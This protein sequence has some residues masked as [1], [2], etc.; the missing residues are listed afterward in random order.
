M[1]RFIITFSKRVRYVL[2]GDRMA[3]RLF[4][5]NGI[6]GIFNDELTPE[7][8]TELGLAIGSCYA[9]G[10]VVV[11]CDSRTSSFL[12]SRAVIAGLLSTGCT[13]HDAGPAPTPAI[14]FAVRC[15]RLDGA[16]IVTASHNPPEYNGIKV[17][18]KD[19]VEIARDEEETIEARFFQ[20]AYRR[21][22][23]DALGSHYIFPT[24]IDAYKEAVKKQVDAKAISAKRFKVVVDPANSVGALS[25]PHL[26]RELGCELVSINAHLDGT[27]PGRL[28]EPK[29]ETLGGLAATVKAVGADLGVAHDGDADRCVFVD[30][31]GVVCLGDRT[32]ALM[33]DYLLPRHPDATVVTPISSSRIIEDVTHH[34]GATL[35]WTKVGS[36]TVSKRMQGLNAVL[37]LEDNGGLF[38]APHQP[39]RDGALAASLML[40]ILAKRDRPLSELLQDLPQYSIVKE[41]VE[42][43]NELKPAVLRGVVA[44]TNGLKR[45][46]LDGVKVFYEDGSV[47]IRPSGT[48]AIYRVYAEAN[49]ERRAKEIAAWGLSLVNGCLEAAS[50]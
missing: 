14:Q 44:R 19:G 38:Y 47:L 32:G 41:R 6:R 36:T 11:G 2:R 42:C 43:P 18:A 26:L 48:E 21:G 27:F 45:Q 20:K 8:A 13:V 3:H 4:G 35:V 22:A 15:Y 24:I 31:T 33:L 28:P 7:Y 29:P 49:D 23:W 50:G 40:E 46:T 17:V 5:T 12:L 25:T 10:K 9:D 30:E 39:V 16:V 1:E 37:G 34:R